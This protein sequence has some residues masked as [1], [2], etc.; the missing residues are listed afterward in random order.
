M[1]STALKQE[2]GDYEFVPPGRIQGRHAYGFLLADGSLIDS[3]ARTTTHN[4]LQDQV[5]FE[6]LIKAQAIRVNG[7]DNIEVLHAA[8]TEQQR[9]EIARFFRGG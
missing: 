9:A 8:P 1:L 7:P 4:Q 6:P 5:G 2:R 3:D